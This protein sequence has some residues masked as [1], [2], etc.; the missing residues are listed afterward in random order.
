MKMFFKRVKNFILSIV[1]CISVVCS[2]AYGSYQVS[3]ASLV[4]AYTAFTVWQ[5]IL[6]TLGVTCLAY[7]TVTHNDAVAEL[8][9]NFD[10]W[11]DERNYANKDEISA[12]LTGAV[13]AGAVAGK[14]SLKE[15]VWDAL[16]DWTADVNGYVRP[17]A[18]ISDFGTI[19]SGCNFLTA[20]AITCANE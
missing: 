17:V 1:L 3:A 5:M 8:E 18:G 20:A 2:G 16:K 19:T 10:T 9:G 15:T 7:D 12:A 4:G 14:V 13:S 11:M 6:L